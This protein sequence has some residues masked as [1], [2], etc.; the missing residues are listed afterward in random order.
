MS[1]RTIKKVN[2]MQH[3]AH[4]QIQEALEY[5]DATRK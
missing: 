1:A 3:A 5:I 4:K 2:D